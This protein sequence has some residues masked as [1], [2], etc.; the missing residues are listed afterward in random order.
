MLLRCRQY[1]ARARGKGAWTTYYYYNPSDQSK[2]QER[3]Y[4]PLDQPPD[5]AYGRV[6]NPE[7]FEPLHSAMMEMISRLEE[8]FDVVRVEGYG[9]DEELE[10]ERGIARPSVQLTPVD[11]NAAPITVAFSDF[12]GLFIRFGRW[13]TEP[14]PSCG[15][16]ACDESAADEIERLTELVDIVTA[17]GFREAIKCPRGPLA[18]DAWLEHEFRAPESARSGKSRIH[19]PRALQMSGGARRLDLRW[20]PWPRR[21]A[22]TGH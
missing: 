3:V 19:R 9:L 13:I 20:H 4:E 16:D 14:F 8:T 11:S 15:C 18:R 5:E 6:T 10:G 21:Q 1:L 17:G 2:R 22:P 7:R 12:P